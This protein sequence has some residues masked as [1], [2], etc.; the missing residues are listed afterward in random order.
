[1]TANTQLRPEV[2]QPGWPFQG[3]RAVEEFIKGVRSSGMSLTTYTE[4]WERA[5]G[6]RST[7]AT[8]REH[9]L[10]ELMRLGLQ[11]D[12]LDITNLATFEFAV[13]RVIQ[14]LPAMARN[15]VNPN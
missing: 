2:N 1:M 6:V 9:R 10:L 14:I 12:L 13:R 15:P 5:S 11:Y 7:S 8:A 4:H 3:P